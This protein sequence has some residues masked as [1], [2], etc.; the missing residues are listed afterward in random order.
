M[1]SSCISHMIW[2]LDE[3]LTEF[4]HE[5]CKRLLECC[6]YTERLAQAAL[7]QHTAIQHMNQI[8]THSERH[9]GEGKKEVDPQCFGVPRWGQAG[10]LQ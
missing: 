9:S 5:L 7:R 3:V 10:C 1:G 8:K 4:L 2:G 6:K